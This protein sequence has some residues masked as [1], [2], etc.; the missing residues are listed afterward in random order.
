[1]KDIREKYIVAGETA[2]SA[3]L[4]LPSEAV[5]A[6]LYANF[7]NVVEESYRARVWIVSPTTMMALLNTVRAVLRDVEMRKEAGQIKIEVDRMLED[8][9]RLNERVRKL[10]GHFEQ[11]RGD[12]DQIRISTEG[13]VRHGE[14]IRAVEL[15]E[16]KVELAPVLPPA[17]KASG[18]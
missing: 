15:G 12:V 5:Y 9:V 3:L 7:P 18:E 14:R 6:E 2:E 13:I 1:V 16:A 17:A 10:G 4:F 11:A 8:V